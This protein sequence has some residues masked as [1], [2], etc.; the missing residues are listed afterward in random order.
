M[1][2]GEKSERVIPGPARDRQGDD[3][4]R[5]EEVTELPEGIVTAWLAAEDMRRG[6]RLWREP[7]Y[8]SIR[9]EEVDLIGPN[10]VEVCGYSPTP[11]GALGSPL[12]TLYLVRGE[13]VRITRYCR[14]GDTL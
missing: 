8:P 9:L 14:E 11:P 13:Q 12:T 1:S 5:F 10:V 3:L 7:P 6:D 2:H 4:D